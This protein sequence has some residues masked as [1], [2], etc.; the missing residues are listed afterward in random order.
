MS[1]SDSTKQDPLAVPSSM[2][3]ANTFVGSLAPLF[4]EDNISIPQFMTKYNPDNVSHDKIVH[5]DTISGKALTYGG[6]R[7]EAAKCAWGLRHILHF[8]EG[9]VLALL[10]PSSVRYPHI[11]RMAS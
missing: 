10:C 9:A 3:S 4:L 2:A 5:I 11:L 6:L 1:L 8:K 7:T